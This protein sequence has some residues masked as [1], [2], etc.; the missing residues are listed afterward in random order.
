MKNN[1]WDRRPEGLAGEQL[2]AWALT[3]LALAIH[4]HYDA[5]TEK[6]QETELEPEP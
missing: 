1:I 4:C 6:I 3:E 2:I 5:I